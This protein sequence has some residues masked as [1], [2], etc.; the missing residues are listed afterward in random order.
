MRPKATARFRLL[1]G[2]AAAAGVAFAHGLAYLLA[3]P[4][5]HAREE[6]LASTGHGSWA[7]M[8]PAAM[9]LLVAGLAGFVWTRV[10]RAPADSPS[11]IF[12][13]AAPRLAL[14]QTVF[15]VLLEAAER[16]STGHSLVSLA[17][18]PVVVIGVVGQIV[19]ALLG[20]AF[21]ALFSKVV[22]A[23]VAAVRRSA[24][25]APRSLP[26][27]FLADTPS[28]GSRLALGG[29]TVRGPPSR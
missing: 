28:L 5:S 24:L 23:I 22:D 1:L 20:A 17:A 29:P 27:R 10:R 16:L 3:E 2:G 21:L 15:F 14:L 6:L 8:I 12:L 18:E 13:E 7:L 11:A 9:A 26:R 19:V 4:N 25:R